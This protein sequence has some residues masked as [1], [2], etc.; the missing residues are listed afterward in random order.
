MGG[1]SSGE[2]DGTKVNNNGTIN[3]HMHGYDISNKSAAGAQSEVKN[4][5]VL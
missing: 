1:I 2:K 5:T 3:R 4:I